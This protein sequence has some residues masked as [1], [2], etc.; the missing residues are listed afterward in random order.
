GELDRA[1]QSMSGNLSGTGE[2]T[3]YKSSDMSMVGIK[4]D[5][6]DIAVAVNQKEPVQQTV[7]Q[8]AATTVPLD[9]TVVNPSVVDSPV[10][11]P[12]VNLPDVTEDQ[13]STDKENDFKKALEEQVQEELKTTDSFPEHEDKTMAEVPETDLKTKKEQSEDELKITKLK[14]EPEKETENIK[15]VINEENI[16]IIP[17]DIN[18]SKVTVAKDK[19]DLPSEPS[20]KEDKIKS[21]GAASK[22]LDI[23]E[24]NESSRE[25][26]EEKSKLTDT[27]K[28]AE[29]LIDILEDIP[30]KK[31]VK[32][33]DIKKFFDANPLAKEEE[34]ASPLD[35][36]EIELDKDDFEKEE[37]LPGIKEKEPGNIES[38]KS[39][40]HQ[41]D[42]RSHLEEELKKYNLSKNKI[43]KEL[44]DV[45]RPKEELESKNIET[46]KNKKYQH[47]NRS[48]LE[49]LLK[50]Y[51]SSKDTG[52]LDLRS[53]TQ[54]IGSEEDFPDLTKVLENYKFSEEEDKSETTLIKKEPEIHEFDPKDIKIEAENLEEPEIEEPANADPKIPVDPVDI[55][56]NW[57]NEDRD[58]EDFQKEEDEGSANIDKDRSVAKQEKNVPEGVTVEKN[59]DDAEEEINGI[60]G[61][62]DKKGH[63]D[64]WPEEEVKK[65]DTEDS[66]KKNAGEHP[67]TSYFKEMLEHK[68]DEKTEKTQKKKKLKKKKNHKSFKIIFAFLISLGIIFGCVFAVSKIPKKDFLTEKQKA[69]QTL[70][71]QFEEP[72]YLPAGFVGSLPILED[73]SSIE[74]PYTNVGDNAKQIKIKQSS[75]FLTEDKILEQYINKNSSD[76]TKES[77]GKSNIYYFDNST[78]FVKDKIVIFVNAS[79]KI[80]KSELKNIAESML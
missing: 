11:T 12:V 17:E 9:S 30:F 52:L 22:L 75:V 19:E 33:N 72:K 70:N 44:D 55:V 51:N 48:R 15:P 35:A 80:D 49:K 24:K 64:H 23:L 60:H 56:T 20:E 50:N 10:D 25:K 68:T 26:K 34:I 32:N 6:Q 74:V 53:D 31:Q 57:E 43:V 8:Q 5:N 73:G 59:S 40:S 67:L 76:Y 16:E 41:D 28:G 14:S 46:E 58:F 45:K 13:I 69:V 37:L 3:S 65:I 39:K 79:F 47:D 63:I 61:L 71:F 4:N 78:I 77:F 36:P 7:D 29:R 27:L 38:E 2:E 21:L 66:R 42:D 18:P 1:F 62:G 54:E